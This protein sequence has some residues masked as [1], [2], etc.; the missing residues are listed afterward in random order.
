LSGS[1]R[2]CLRATNSRPRSEQCVSL[3]CRRWTASRCHLQVESIPCLPRTNIEHTN[4]SPPLRP[5]V[6]SLAHHPNG[7]TVRRYAGGWVRVGACGRGLRPAPGRLRGTALGVLRP[8][9]EELA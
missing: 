2:C 3:R 6:Y 7:A 9:C 8:L 1:G 4:L 5:R